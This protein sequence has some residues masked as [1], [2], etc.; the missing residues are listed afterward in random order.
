VNREIGM[1]EWDRYFREVLGGSERGEG[2]GRGEAGEGIGE[3]REGEEEMGV[4]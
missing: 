3:V 2:S 4:E 1:E